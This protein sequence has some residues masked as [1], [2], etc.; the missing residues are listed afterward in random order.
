MFAPVGSVD[1]QSGP[2]RRAGLLIMLGLMA[3]WPS[4]ARDAVELAD[5]SLEEL[6][7]IKVTSVARKDQ[8]VAHT[9]AAVYVITSEEIRRSGMT[10]VPDLLRMAPGVHVAQVSAGNWAVSAR[11]FNGEFAN[12]LLVLVDGRSIYMPI[13]GGVNWDALD[14]MPE[15]IERIEVIRGPGA[16][17]WGANAVNGVINII[18]R[19]AADAQGTLVT[20]SAGN[21]LG[22]G[23]VR[24]GGALGNVGHFHTSANYSR[25]SNAR[26]PEV[27]GTP[28][29][30]QHW[31]AGTGSLRMDLAPR[32]ADQVTVEAM[33]SQGHH[34]LRSPEANLR[35]PHDAGL[36]GE[37]Q[38][39]YGGVT[40]RWRRALDEASSVELLGWYSHADRNEAAGFTAVRAADFEARYR[41]SLASRHEMSLAG[42]VRRQ[43]DTT[44]P[45]LAIRF[46]PDNRTYYLYSATLQDEVRLGSDRV[47]LHFG[48][49]FEHYD[50]GGF[51]VQPAAGLFWSASARQSV[52]ASVSRA[53]RL[54]ARYELDIISRLAI[55]PASPETMGLPV[56]VTLFGNR[57]IKPES[58][59]SIESGY[60]LQLSKRLSL[61][62]T[63]F[64]N[65]YNRLV[66][67]VRGV[68]RVVAAPEPF[69]EAPITVANSREGDSQG[70]E[71]ALSTW[72]H[73]RWKL[74]GS[75]TGWRFD[76]RS[77]IPAAGD[78]EAVPS[79]PG[80]QV[81][82]QSWLDLPGRVQFDTLY[83]A[84]SSLAAKQTV[85]GPVPVVPALHRLDL[86][87][88]WQAARNFH[89]SLNLQNALHP[90][91]TEYISERSIHYHQIRRGL[92]G[93]VA[94]T[95]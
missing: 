44:R 80:H 43:A 77:R 20:A 28:A 68:P 40:G 25:R 91:R 6:L 66:N 15:N 1:V 93:K 46:V 22:G 4:R 88:G 59:V 89:L 95:F 60:R 26:E 42:E 3:M 58:V 63:G 64:W 41:R 83:F 21:T 31:E 86:R 36:T 2:A 82:I 56:A 55:L 5:L 84:A 35:V 29:A 85:V 69:L 87:L 17:M 10:S 18:T 70:F 16:T 48:S 8:Q 45:G 67:V 94:W 47:V 37:F 30:D 11:G 13:F 78:P 74:Q 24:H 19:R 90:Y 23:A 27:V 32:P 9:A 54:P 51:Q 52:W 57:D 81:K 7:E 79:D 73:P 33:V 12:K 14:L 76:V 71:A 49:R 38:P 92:F 53:T 61:D 72:I 39:R 75:Y 50:L 65:R 34:D 62:T